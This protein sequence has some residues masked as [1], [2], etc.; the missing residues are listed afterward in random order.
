[1]K[2]PLLIGTLNLILML[3]LFGSCSN[4]ST[5]EIE[6]TLSFESQFIGIWKL[7]SIQYQNSMIPFTEEDTYAVF[8]KDSTY[9]GY[10]YFGNGAGT[11]KYIDKRITCFIDNEN[12]A[13]YTILTLNPTRAYL[14]VY[15][16]QSNLTLNLICKKQ[17]EIPEMSS[18]KKNKSKYFEIP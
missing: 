1:M 8:H 12:F 9:E 18:I 17:A 10:G 11:W 16:F 15:L 2:K 3:L 5:K 13:E 7:D 4:S 14:K 6:D